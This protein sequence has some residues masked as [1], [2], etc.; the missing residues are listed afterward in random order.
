MKTTIIT[1]AIMA[2]TTTAAM[3]DNVPQ[4][5]V[6]DSPATVAV[7]AIGNGTPAQGVVRLTGPD[8][9]QTFHAID[10]T[11]TYRRAQGGTAVVN[12]GDGFT[13]AH[14]AELRNRAALIASLPPVDHP[15][16]SDTFADLRA[17]GEDAMY[18]A[19]GSVAL[20]QIDLPHAGGIGVSVGSVDGYSSFAVKGG[21]A[22][23]D[24]MTVSAGL[25]TSEGVSGGSVAAVWGF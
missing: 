5:G 16:Y 17:A 23:T 8:G 7:T 20:A 6:K 9:S 15:D 4:G 24:Q 13:N 19:S 21:Y 10:H 12:G 14:E 11:T 2:L 22:V 25:F 1:A 3:A 18:A